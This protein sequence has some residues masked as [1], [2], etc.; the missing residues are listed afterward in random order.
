MKERVLP[1]DAEKEDAARAIS[2][3]LGMDEAPDEAADYIRDVLGA[4]VPGM[5]EAY[6]QRMS[7]GG[8]A[9]LDN[10]QLPRFLVDMIGVEMFEGDLGKHMRPLLLR[11][12]MKKRPRKLERL[13]KMSQTQQHAQTVSE[14]DMLKDLEGKKW[15]R[16]GTFAQKFTE[17]LGFPPVFAGTASEPLPGRVVDVHPRTPYRELVPFQENMKNQVIEMLKSGIGPRRAILTLPTGAGKTKIV[18]EAV[19]ETWSGLPENM[20]FI[21]W[22]AQTDELCEQAVSCFRQI[23]EERGTP[24]VPLRIFRVWKGRGIPHPEERGIIV[25]GIAQLNGLAGSDSAGDGD[26]DLGA[27]GNRMGAVFVDEAHRSWAP[28]YRRVLGAIGIPTRPRTC[29]NIPMIGLTATPERTAAGETERLREFY[30]GRTIRPR[31]E[32]E[33][34]S[35]RDGNPFDRSWSDIGAMRERLTRSGYLASPRYHYEDPAKEFEMSGKET[36]R[37]EQQHM[38]DSDFLRRIGTDTDRNNAT[39]GLL[40]K[41]ARDR[42]RKVL[43]F[44]ANV[45]QAL[46]MS[47]FLEDDGIRSATITSTTGYGARKGRVR[48]FRDGEIQVLCNFEVLTTG[49]DAPDVDTII[50]ARPTN[51]MIVYQQMVGR[52]LRGPEFGGTETCDIITVEDMI[53]TSEHK[54]VE[55][56]YMQYKRDVDC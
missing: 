18:A 11:G 36:E 51:S 19:T 26:S 50:I 25:A 38:F 2:R 48:M 4:Y 1:T 34:D 37:F 39:Y 41:W 14:S 27:L 52:G 10:A 53:R 15:Y 40:K 45:H 56:G 43:F 17:M 16:G 55:L 30:G 5:E 33:P 47:R 24:G 22:I 49:F 54:Q 12:V 21:L 44:G 8:P 7:P 42:R 6:A 32:Y 31:Q 13:H 46:L 35:D 9:V 3:W 23:W 29:D 28:E 20:H